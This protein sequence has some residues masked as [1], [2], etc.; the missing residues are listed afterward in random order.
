MA[1]HQLVAEINGSNNEDHREVKVSLFPSHLSANN[2][3]TNLHTGR[4][5]A[6]TRPVT[7]LARK[8]TRLSIPAN[9]PW[10]SSK[11]L[12]RTDRVIQPRLRTTSAMPP[13]SPPTIKSTGALLL[14]LLLTFTFKYITDIEQFKICRSNVCC[15]RFRF[16]HF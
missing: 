11:K 6:I 12:V 14:T 13:L 1:N 4:W 9:I 5:K 16:L 7:T 15:F 3:V 10:S 8:A 2:Y